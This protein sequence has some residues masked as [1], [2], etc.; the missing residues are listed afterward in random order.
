MGLNSQRFQRAGMVTKRPGGRRKTRKGSRSVDCRER[1][2]RAPCYTLSLVLV[3]FCCLCFAYPGSA[4]SIYFPILATASDFYFSSRSLSSLTSTTVLVAWRG[5][6]AGSGRDSR[7]VGQGT[8]RTRRA[9]PRDGETR[10]V[11]TVEDVFLEVV[12]SVTAAEGPGATV[13]ERHSL[14]YGRTIITGERATGV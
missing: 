14:V 12:T 10:G 6:G 8:V 9:L 4:S 5:G 1:R 11:C 7:R 3:L 2:E 13:A